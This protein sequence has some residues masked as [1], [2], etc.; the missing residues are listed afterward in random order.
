MKI[1]PVEQVIVPPS[2]DRTL[3][4]LS[5]RVHQRHDGDRNAEQFRSELHQSVEDLIGPGIQQPG[6]LERGEPFLF[7]D[8]GTEWGGHGGTMTARLRVAGSHRATP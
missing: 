1:S 6:S 4:K 3:E 7:L 8:I 2:G 5:L